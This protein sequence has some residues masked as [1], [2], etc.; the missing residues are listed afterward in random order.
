MAYRIFIVC[1][2][3]LLIKKG[4]NMDIIKAEKVFYW[5]MVVLGATFFGTAFFMKSGIDIVMRIVFGGL[6]VLGGLL[7][8]YPGIVAKASKAFAS[9]IISVFAGSAK[10]IKRLKRRETTNEADIIET[11]RL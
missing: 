1:V 10:K 9:M 11:K 7:E 4:G 3:F 6:V 8:I 2:P 5:V